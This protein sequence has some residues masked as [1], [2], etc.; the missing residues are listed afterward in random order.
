[1]G[2]VQDQVAVVSGAATGLGKSI[3]LRLAENGARVVLGDI[4]GPGLA[5]T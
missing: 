4:D 1:M 2:R 3:A 5:A